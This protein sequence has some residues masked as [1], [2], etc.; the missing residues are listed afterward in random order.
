MN[1]A[2][3][4]YKIVYN[5][6]NITNDVSNH[7]KAMT[8]TD[9]VG[10]EAD[11]LSILLEDTDLMWQNDWY[12][13]K[14]AKL[15]AEIE[16]NGKVLK[17]GDFTID[18]P[19]FSF[20]RSGDEIAIRAVSA[21][22]TNQVRTKRSSA[23]ENK[24]LSEIARTVAGRHGFTVVG[25]VPAITIGRV[26]QKQ[27]SDLNFLQALA[28]QYGIVFSIRGKQ[29]V[30]TDVFALEGTGAIMTIDKSEVV[31]GSIRDKSADTYRKA[32][33]TAHNPD[34][35]ETVES[36]TEE[37]D[38][39]DVSDILEIR[40]K[41]ENKQ[42]A[43]RMAIAELHW[44]NSMQQEGSIVVPGN[45]LLISGVNFELTGVGK[46]SGIYN[47]LESTHS[48]DRSGG[49]STSLSIKRVQKI[50]SSKFKP[51]NK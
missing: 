33:A 20:S 32:I 30:F 45:P 51:K 49:Y 25:S 36:D 10:G 41:A 5:G 47:I 12:P 42:Q 18:E 17:C 46:L 9:K 31:S 21:F 13:E 29:M 1:L 43:E 11:E 2:S 16:L 3:A 7:L 6:T 44:K 50:D 15:T 48:L 37:D 24:T 26:T 23:H 34:T 27:Q 39:V 28:V 22:F 35:K 19:E 14:M 4:T 40:R 8:Y 38:D